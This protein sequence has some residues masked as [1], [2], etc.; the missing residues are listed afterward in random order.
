MKNPSKKIRRPSRVAPLAVESLEDRRLLSGFKSL[1]HEPHHE[2]SLL[3]DWVQTASQ[4]TGFL[5]SSPQIIAGGN[6]FFNVLP[7][8][9]GIPQSSPSQVGQGADLPAIKD[10]AKADHAKFS[11]DAIADLIVSA[12]SQKK[13]V[14]SAPKSVMHILQNLITQYFG[15]LNSISTPPSSDNIDS[16]NA[17]LDHA[18]SQTG[19]VGGGSSAGAGLG[20]YQ[21]S[22]TEENTIDKGDSG[23]GAA[24]KNVEVETH[25]TGTDSPASAIP[26]S[27]ITSVPLTGE[28]TSGPVAN[29]GA[30]RSSS[31]GNIAAK[32]GVLS[33]DI[34]VSHVSPKAATAAVTAEPPK[35]PIADQTSLVISKDP[36]Q[37][38]QTAQDSTVKPSL[39][40]EIV[41]VGFKPTQSPLLNGN[42]A[43]GQNE[44]TGEIGYWSFAGFTGIGQ[45]E[46]FTSNSGSFTDAGS[47][48]G[49]LSFAPESLLAA[50]APAEQS[51][52]DTAIRSF[53]A[54]LDDMGKEAGASL[55]QFHTP[56]WLLS[57]VG[58]AMVAEFTR[59]RTRAPI[60]GTSLAGDDQLSM[61][62]WYPAFLGMTT[63]D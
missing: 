54:N 29:A 25:L 35:E 61:S 47:D 26:T 36:E 1:L 50:G 38:R 12:A 24:K 3:T 57:V 59:R 10:H 63:A 62:T 13:S 46:R 30:D 4:P 37:V 48:E 39:A 43:T 23:S 31:T 8:L 45:A 20:N 52:L 16:N 55:T 9:L 40:T 17:N 53:F 6:A 60:Q 7:Q 32:T 42:L 5:G 51:G 22:V 27:F 44:A 28:T 2:L 14:E 33:I 11:F 58:F 41:D 49:V 34:A 15:K 18:S 56:A 21:G 19:N